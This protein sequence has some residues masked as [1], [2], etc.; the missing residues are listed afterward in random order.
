MEHLKSAVR[1][2]QTDRRSCHCCKCKSSSVDG[3]EI[4]LKGVHC[5]II[6]TRKSLPEDRESDLVARE[7]GACQKTPPSGDQDPAAHT[8]YGVQRHKP[9]AQERLGRGGVG[10]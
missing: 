10:I 5:G 7:E 9:M 4:I 2:Q 1:I 6:I 8:V 3:L